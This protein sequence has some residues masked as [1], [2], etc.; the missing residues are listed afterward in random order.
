MN[1]DQLLDLFHARS[2]IICAVGAG[3]K[4]S[5]LYHLLR[6]HPGRTAFAATVFT[7]TFP[8]D[9]GLTPI[10]AEEH[11]VLECTLS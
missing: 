8:G 5:I 1:A 3:G 11:R 10:V 2:G 6:T 4:K 7:R 9:L